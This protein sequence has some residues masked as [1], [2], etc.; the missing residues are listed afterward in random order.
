MFH[1]SVVS[2]SLTLL[3]S[4]GWFITTAP[5][6]VSVNSF[7]AFPFSRF[8]MG[9]LDCKDLPN[10]K[11]LRLYSILILP[12]KWDWGSLLCA[13]SNISLFS[14]GQ[15]CPFGLPL[16][17]QNCNAPDSDVASGSFVIMHIR[18]IYIFL[19]SK[20]ECLIFLLLPLK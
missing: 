11:C 16:P 10:C 14:R 17:P 13:P 5:F 6:Q 3:R 12:L 19:G 15:L 2:Y 7:Y 1:S 9:Y 4:V 8:L 20:K 18:Q